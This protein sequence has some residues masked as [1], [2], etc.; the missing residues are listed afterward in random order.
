[1]SVRA[2]LLVVAPLSLTASIAVSLGSAQAASRAVGPSQS[3]CFRAAHT[4]VR[5]AMPRPTVLRHRVQAHFN[6]TLTL[7][8]VP[9]TSRP[10]VSPESAWAT[11]GPQN[12]GGDK[13]LLLAYLSSSIPA[14]LQPD[15]SL[16]PDYQH[17]LAWVDYGK[18]LPFDTSTA[19]QLLASPPGA[20]PTCMFVGQGITAWN[21]MTGK[22]IVDSGFVPNDGR[23]LHLQVQRWDPLTDP[24]MPK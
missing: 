11:I 5:I 17:V 24:C 10:P 22:R 15:G 8:P 6:G 23:T 14:S 4:F 18:R 3:A 2:A 16:R 21:A 7:D 9:R 13:Q 1:M 12:P 19:S 20:K